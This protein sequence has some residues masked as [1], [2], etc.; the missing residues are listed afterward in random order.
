MAHITDITETQFK[1]L[2]NQIALVDFWA[3]WCGP[4]LRMHPILEEQ[5]APQFDKTNPNT[6]HPVEFYKLNTDEHQQIAF[7]LNIR[8]IPNMILFHFDAEGKR[9]E[10][11]SF[12]GVQDAFDMTMK[13]NEILAQHGTSSSA[14]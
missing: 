14:T 10:L 7:D 8:S 6:Q 2:K 5:V 1:E 11:H 13:M 3:P 4:C 9:T 12:I